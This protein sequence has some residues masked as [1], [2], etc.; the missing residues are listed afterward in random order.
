V[1]RN[2]RRTGVG[3]FRRSPLSL[4]LSLA[5]SD[6]DQTNV[7]IIGFVEPS[8]L[9]LRPATRLL[10]RSLGLLRLQIRAT[11]AA[12]VETLLAAARLVRSAGPSAC[13]G[14]R[15]GG[16]RTAFGAMRS[17]SRG[18]ARDVPGV[19]ASAGLCDR[20]T[21]LCGQLHSQGCLTWRQAAASRHVKEALYGPLKYVLCINGC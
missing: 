16:N 7:T 21:E 19:Q 17:F 20:I 13:S 11:A 1:F 12:S 9:P 15:G 4:L 3:H 14:L 5:A 6:P 8:R 10:L 18:G 2:K